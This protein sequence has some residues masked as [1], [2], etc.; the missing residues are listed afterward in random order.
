MTQTISVAQLRQM[1][2]TSRGS[3]FVT[4]VARTSARARKTANPHWP[5]TKLAR[6]NGVIGFNYGLTVRRQQLREGR[7]L[8][9]KSE[10]RDWGNRMDP[11]TPKSAMPAGRKKRR[12]GLCPLYCHKGRDYL[13]VKVE[14]VLEV[15]YFAGDGREM[16]F[17]QVERFL[18]VRKCNAKHQGVRRQ[19]VLRDYHLESIESITFNGNSYLVRG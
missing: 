19:I 8:T 17:D 9:F 11:A 14:R 6:V 1:L 16:R 2:A 15:S 10:P 4:F 7:R 3:C 13:D 12:R 18:P 5:V